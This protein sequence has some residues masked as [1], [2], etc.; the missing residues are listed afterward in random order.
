MPIDKKNKNK[1]KGYWWLAAKGCNTD[2]LEIAISELEKEGCLIKNYG[3]SVSA[4]AKGIIEQKKIEILLGLVYA[5][6]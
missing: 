5:V 2:Y 3:G 6:E 4:T 1:T